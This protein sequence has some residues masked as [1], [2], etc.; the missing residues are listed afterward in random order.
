MPVS[1]GGGVVV[2]SLPAA[3]LVERAPVES[4]DVR[5]CVT[6]F[7]QDAAVSSANNAAHR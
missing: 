6:T 2:S 3:G 5:A 7:W 1:D 4:D